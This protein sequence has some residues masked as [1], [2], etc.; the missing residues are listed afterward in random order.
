MSYTKYIIFVIITTALCAL[1]GFILGNTG[2]G[3]LIGF[4]ASAIVSTEVNSYQVDKIIKEMKE[5]NS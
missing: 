1:V 4:I 5:S 2:A 3:A